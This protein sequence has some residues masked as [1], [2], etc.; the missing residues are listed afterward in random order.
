MPRTKSVWFRT[1]PAYGLQDK[2]GVDRNKNIIYG[3]AIATKGEAKGHDV[4]LDDQ[5]LATI[6]DLGN[7][8]ERGV[9]ARFT[10]PNMSNDGMGS[11]LGR[12]R[13]F[14]VDGDIVRADLHFSRRAFNTPK[15]NLAGYVMGLAE[16]EPDM[17]GVSIVI[18]ET[19]IH[20]KLEGEEMAF[21][22]PT[23]LR[24]ADVVDSPAANDGFFSEDSPAAQATTILDCLFGG[25]PE[26]V[27]R[28][29]VYAFLDSY[30]AS[31]QHKENDMADSVST[32]AAK[33][34]GEDVS[35]T[36]TNK[37]IDEKI[38]KL[39]ADLMPVALGEPV[40][41][42]ART[43][44]AADIS[45]QLETARTEG[46]EQGMVYAGEVQ[47]MCEMVDMA[48]KAPGFIDAKLSLIE[49]RRRLSAEQAEQRKP[50]GDAGGSDLLEKKDPA[51]KYRQEFKDQ[52]GEDELGVSEADYAA[53]CMTSDAKGI[54]GK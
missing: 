52:G 13:D 35:A 33:T 40:L 20:E 31:Q 22:R 48:D 29:R 3:A 25:D 36:Y 50:V 30:F 38:A 51:A 32:G 54:V 14:R 27:V 34:G 41:L 18:P 6:A 21:L 5:T 1:A 11:F 46:Y 8:A 26:S 12:W 39:K 24:A 16:D 2:Q 28:E 23:K 37:Q 15:G 10:H 4:M 7:S 49:V 17:F 47:A 53:S 9:K 42:E 45:D 19:D 43:T 44:D